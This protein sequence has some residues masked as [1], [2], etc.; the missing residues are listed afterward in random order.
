MKANKLNLVSKR[1]DVLV[2][3]EVLDPM[4]PP[5]GWTDD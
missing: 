4:Y 2:C 1:A 3:N 5:G